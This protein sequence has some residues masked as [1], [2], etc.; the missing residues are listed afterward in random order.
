MHLHL[1]ALAWMFVVLLMT[2]AEGT[3][4]QGSWLGAFFTFMLYGLLP[5]GLLLYILATPARRRARRAGESGEG[6]ASGLQ[7]DGRRHAAGD[8]VASEGEEA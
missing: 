2:L 6:E 7:P 3:S 1:V 4:P 8:A 5:L